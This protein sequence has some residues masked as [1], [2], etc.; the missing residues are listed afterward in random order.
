MEAEVLTVSSGAGVES[1]GKVADCGWQ[2][3]NS[4]EITAKG[5]TRE[6]LM[7]AHYSGVLAHAAGRLSFRQTSSLRTLGERLSC[8]KPW[9]SRGTGL[10]ISPRMDATERQAFLSEDTLLLCDPIL[11]ELPLSLRRSP[12]TRQ[13]LELFVGPAGMHLPKA[14]VH[15]ALTRARYCASL[16]DERLLK[17]V[18]RLARKAERRG[19]VAPLAFPRDHSLCSAYA[20]AWVASEGPFNRPAAK[21]RTTTCTLVL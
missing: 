17:L 12:V 10:C 3:A 19:F 9:N 2:P 8:F 21:A 7:G 16:H 5:A 11:G 13:L 14:D 15:A 20:L 18:Q 6:R 4:R 1:F